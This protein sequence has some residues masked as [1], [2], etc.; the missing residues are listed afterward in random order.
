[1]KKNL[2]KKLKMNKVTIT[3]LDRGSMLGV[4]GG[5]AEV[6]IDTIGPM[7]EPDTNPAPINGKPIL[8]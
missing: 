4:Q 3:T 8:W 1:M 5:S 6:C 7:C 2:G